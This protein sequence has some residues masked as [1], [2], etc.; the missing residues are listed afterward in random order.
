MPKPFTFPIRRWLAVLIVLLLALGISVLFAWKS[1][2]PKNT[3]ETAT[4][5]T[6]HVSFQPRRQI[7]TSGYT[8]VLSRI[9]QWSKTATLEEIAAPWPGCGHRFINELDKHLR[10][11][12]N[13]GTFHQKCSTKTSSRKVALLNYEGEARKAYEVL[14]ELRTLVENDMR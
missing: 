8:L 14:K 4:S 5:E 2:E 1:A 7:D 6:P 11:I 13:R 10:G 9:P 12:A 3:V